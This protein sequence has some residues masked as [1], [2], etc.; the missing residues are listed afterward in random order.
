MLDP[1]SS[2]RRTTKPPR[3]SQVERNNPQQCAA[4]GQSSLMALY[5]S[6]FKVYGMGSGQVLINIADLQQA[7][8]LD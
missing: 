8:T 1:N 3:C 2:K 6:M 4:V 5:D 7:C